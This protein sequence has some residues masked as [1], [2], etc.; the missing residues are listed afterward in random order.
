MLDGKETSIDFIKEKHADAQIPAEV[1]LIEDGIAIT[2]KARILNV[3][4]NGA[5]L[6][7]D[8]FLHVGQ[9]VGIVIRGLKE[10]LFDLFSAD[11][12]NCSG[13]L[14]IKTQGKVLQAK[15]LPDPMTSC[16]AYIHFTGNIHVASTGKSL[17]ELS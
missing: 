4:A 1:L 9:K 7:I 15:S 11:K 14:K 13:E 12:R 2:K 6:E 10:D 3:T 8:Y 17:S 5:L 16:C